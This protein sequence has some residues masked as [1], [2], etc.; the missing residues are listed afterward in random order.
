[1]REG[2]E[3]KIS[4]FSNPDVFLTLEMRY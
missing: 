1:M 4:L 2:T 3:Y